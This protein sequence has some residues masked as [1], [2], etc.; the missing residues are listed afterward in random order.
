MPL[1]GWPRD[2]PHRCRRPAEGVSYGGT[3]P[4]SRSSGQRARSAALGQEMID[5][6]P[7]RIACR[8][9]PFTGHSAPEFGGLRGKRALLRTIATTSVTMVMSKAALNRKRRLG[10]AT[11]CPT[12]TVEGARCGG[13]AGEQLWC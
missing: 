5:Q 3:Q 8:N 13:A 9:C 10:G 12:W 4:P 1:N 2:K 7:V 6:V 11:T